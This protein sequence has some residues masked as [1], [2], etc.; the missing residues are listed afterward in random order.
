MTAM[1]ESGT[2]RVP[3][4]ING[5]ENALTY[6]QRACF[7]AELGPLENSMDREAVITA[8]WLRAM[9]AAYGD[10][11]RAFRNAVAPVLVAGRARQAGVAA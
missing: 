9:S 11:R 4:S 7:Y 1:A 2:L 5:I 6:E 8:W 3:R 10:D